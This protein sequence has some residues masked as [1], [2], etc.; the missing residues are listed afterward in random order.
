MY[1]YILHIYPNGNHCSILR[2]IFL[3][4]FNTL[5]SND[6]RL[7]ELQRRMHCVAAERRIPIHIQ[8]FS[9]NQPIGFGL[10]RQHRDLMLKHISDF[11]YFL[12]MEE[13]MLF[14]PS[15]LITYLAES[16]K[17]RSIMPSGWVN[18]IPGFLRY[19]FLFLYIY[20][21]IKPNLCCTPCI[22]C[23]RLVLIE[24]YEDRKNKS[25]RVT[26]EYREHKIHIVDLGPRLGKYIMTVNQ[27]Q[28]S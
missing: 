9:N 8:D 7:N 10:N 23:Y 27:N 25:E 17:F 5:S 14:T 28:V 22:I 6:P 15:H 2:S 26:W 3:Q 24:R 20:T 1:A 12:Y 18:F 13:D 19:S 4:V 11:D 21:H 16:N